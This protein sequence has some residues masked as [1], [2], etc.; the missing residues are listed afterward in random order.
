MK[1]MTTM[2]MMGNCRL[3][4]KYDFWRA[5]NLQPSFCPYGCSEEH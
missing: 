2:R 3:D 5:F 1:M 4:G